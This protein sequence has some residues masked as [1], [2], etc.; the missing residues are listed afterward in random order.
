M[1]MKKY[2]FKVSL[3]AKSANVNSVATAYGGGGHVL[4][5]GCLICGELE[6][7]IDKLSYTVSQNL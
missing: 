2:H 5:A 7:V 3:R 1:E 6:E 4:A